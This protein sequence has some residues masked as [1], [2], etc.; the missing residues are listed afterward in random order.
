LTGLAWPLD[1]K[2]ISII[3]LLILRL[4]I[5]VAGWLSYMLLHVLFI[6]IRKN[7]ISL[8]KGQQSNGTCTWFT[9][10]PESG[11]CQLLGSCTNLNEVSCS[12]CS[13][14]QVE[15]QVTEPKCWIA[16]ECDGN[17]LHVEQGVPDR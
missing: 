7:K 16:G 12:T 1:D 2:L 4:S 13:S 14:G 9:Y 3:K 8:L 11:Y 6:I 17:V 10:Y 5:R 15:C